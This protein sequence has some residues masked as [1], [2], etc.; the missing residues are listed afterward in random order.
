M[1]EQNPNADANEQV[2]EAHKYPAWLLGVA[3]VIVVAS[4]YSLFLTPKYYPAA[5]LLGKA[6]KADEAQ[7]VQQAVDLLHQA[8]AKVPDSK[9]IRLELAYEDFKL[10]SQEAH[11]DAMAALDGITMSPDEWAR[12]STVMPAEYQS[13]FKET[14]DK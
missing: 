5:S 2:L 6:E 8:V 7:Q 9:K 1:I 10:P 13:Q 3:G 12:M 11:E 4:I 14:E